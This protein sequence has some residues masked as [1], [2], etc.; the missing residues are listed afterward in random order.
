MF[1]KNTVRFLDTGIAYEK[2]WQQ[3][4]YFVYYLHGFLY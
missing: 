1:K 4:M 3:D 2:S